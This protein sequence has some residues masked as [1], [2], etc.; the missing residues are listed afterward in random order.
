MIKSDNEDKQ[1]NI[2]IKILN[3][4]ISISFL[5]ISISLLLIMFSFSAD[6]PGWGYASEKTP[7]NLYNEYGA[8]IA[9]FIIRELGL[10]TG[11][12]MALVCLNW[13]FKFLKKSTISFFKLKLVSF[14]IMIFL[15]VIG[16]AYIE[17]ISNYYFKLN[18][19]IINQNGFPEWMLSYLSN[20]ANLIFNLQ[21]TNNENIVGLSTFIISI[22]IFLW[23]LSL[24]S[25]ER[26]ILKLIF[27]PFILPLIWILTI[28]FNLFFKLQNREDDILSKEHSFNLTIY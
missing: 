10:F 26:K 3:K 27:R 11:L 24:G 22:I 6:D 7:S 13:S 28:L 2:L 12:L 8:W 14:F 18:F 9:G 25:E 4:I 20:Q 17:K 15:S 19:E 16:G 5:F 23:I 21:L 1:L